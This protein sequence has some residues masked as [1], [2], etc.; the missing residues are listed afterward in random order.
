MSARQQACCDASSRNTRS[1]PTP[2]TKCL[3][4]RMDLERAL[5]ALVP[6]S[7]RAPVRAASVARC[8]ASERAA[9][10]CQASAT[11]AVM[12]GLSIGLPDVG[13]EVSARLGG[14]PDLEMVRGTPG[15]VA[16]RPLRLKA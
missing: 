11:G 2:G 5:R 4:T 3:C 7:R 12:R 9:S 1:L 6:A 16:Q 14:A 13:P 10:H 15:V 8:V